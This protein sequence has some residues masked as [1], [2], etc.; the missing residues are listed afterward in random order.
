MVAFTFAIR[1]VLVH[2]QGKAKVLAKRRLVTCHQPITKNYATK[3]CL[4]V[5][6]HLAA[7]KAMYCTEKICKSS[8]MDKKLVF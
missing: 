2:V 3:H 5:K 4:C 1:L 7:C 6:A 8:G